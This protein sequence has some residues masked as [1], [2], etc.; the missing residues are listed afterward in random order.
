MK[1]NHAKKVLIGSIKIADFEDN[2]FALKLLDKLLKIDEEAILQ[3]SRLAFL[4]NYI[5]DHGALD[6][7]LETVNEPAI[8]RKLKN[9]SEIAL[10]FFSENCVSSERYSSTFEMISHLAVAERANY[11]FKMALA[12]KGDER[13]LID[14]SSD[15]AVSVSSFIKEKSR[16]ERISALYSGA[17][18]ESLKTTDSLTLHVGQ[19]TFDDFSL[20]PTDSK[21]RD[22][23]VEI[24]H[25]QA[26]NACEA[27]SAM[28]KE[29]LNMFMVR[30]INMYFPKSKGLFFR[31]EKDLPYLFSDKEVGAINIDLKR[32]IEN[33]FIEVFKAAY[34][35]RNNRV[36]DRFGASD[37]SM[38]KFKE[39]VNA[40]VK[41]PVTAMLVRAYTLY[42]ELLSETLPKSI[43]IRRVIEYVGGS[44]RSFGVYIGRNPF[45]AHR[46]LSK[47]QERPQHVELLLEIFAKFLQE[48]RYQEYIEN[49]LIPEAKARGED[50]IFGASGW[51]KDTEQ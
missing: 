48:G 18:Y 30:A 17:I 11:L 33:S 1:E 32:P 50:D 24:S 49:I 23:D 7:F 31:K 10:G 15:A 27:L 14:L 46:Y 34:G 45:T 5:F 47:D 21:G 20:K 39:D 44:E 13:P 6:L 9:T 41:D 16:A 4:V 29:D 3:Q 22:I 12:P 51:P 43:D 40:P 37:A 2:A 28:T 38:L 19:V 35:L 8:S 25:E 36:K 42:P 26:K